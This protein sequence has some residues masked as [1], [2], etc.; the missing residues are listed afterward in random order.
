MEIGM[1][2]T[3][4]IGH[5]PACAE[6][7]YHNDIFELTEMI[8]EQNRINDEIL[9]FSLVRE[10]PINRV[11]NKSELYQKIKSFGKNT[12]FI[13]HGFGMRIPMELLEGYQIFN[14]HESELPKYKGAQPTYW[15]TLNNEKQIGVS[16]F[17]ITEH[18][19]EGPIIAQE[20]FPYYY[21]ENENIIQKKTWEIIPKLLQGL[22]EYLESGHILK[23]NTTGDY[24]KKVTRK[25]VF[26][27]LDEDSPQTIFNKVRAEAAFGGAKLI[28]CSDKKSELYCINEI[29][30]SEEEMQV[31]FKILENGALKVK[32]TNK[33]I[34]LSNKY[35]KMETDFKFRGE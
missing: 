30:F 23:Q 18:F 7:I 28:L 17:L 2:K 19:D 22:F 34:I 10:I 31:P 27:N 6:Y 3:V 8:C 13:M 5:V 14:I 9:T 20:R 35:T 26:I 4:Y 1:Y 16:L 11:S 15:A 24:Y 29:L 32:Y 33:L 21:W 12:I 25:D